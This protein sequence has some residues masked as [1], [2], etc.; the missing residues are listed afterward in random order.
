MPAGNGRQ[1]QTGPPLPLDNATTVAGNLLTWLILLPHRKQLLPAVIPCL[2]TPNKAGT[3]ISSWLGFQHAF[4]KQVRDSL[5][6]QQQHLDIE[7]LTLFN[8]LEHR[9]GNIIPEED[10]QESTTDLSGLFHHWQQLWPL[11][12]AQ[13]LLYGYR[14]HGLRVLNKKPNR[15]YT[16]PLTLSSI[17]PKLSFTIKDDGACYSLRL[18]LSIGDTILVNPK[19][20]ISFMIVDESA[21]YL[22]ASLQDAAVVEWM[23]NCGGCLTIFKEH[24]NT[25]LKEILRPLRCCYTATAL[26]ANK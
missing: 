23:H 16:T 8:K 22:L 24:T 10:D 25:F 20:G 26:P 9:D 2:A 13:P 1:Q 7:C 5:S 15:N 6:K 21:L 19:T 4:T 3:A 14:F 12:Q 17:R 11:L 18:Q